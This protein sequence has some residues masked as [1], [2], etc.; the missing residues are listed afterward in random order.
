MDIEKLVRPNIK[1]LKPYSSAR[2]LFTGNQAM[3]L[4]ANENAFDLF[5][6]SLNR[7]PDPLQSELKNK[8]AELKGVTPKNIFLGNGSDEAI[9]L[10][11]RIFCQPG[12]DEVILC[13]P[14]YGMYE[15]MANIH[16]ANIK[17]VLLSP[18]FQLRP[19][20]ILNQ[21]NSSS[22][23]LFLCS[24]NNPTGNLL[25]SE[26]ILELL[27]KFPSIVIVDEAYGDFNAVSWANKVGQFPNLVVL[28][29]LSKAWGLAGLR[30]G[31]AIA[32]EEIVQYLNAVKYPYNISRLNQTAALSALQSPEKMNEAVDLLNSE[33]NELAK[34]LLQLSIVERVFPS[35]ANFILVKFR[36]SSA[37]FEFL[38]KQNIIVRDRS[39]EPLC[40]NCLRLSIGRPEE[41][42]ALFEALK[43]SD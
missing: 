31:M 13:P 6:G 15:V 1:S 25:I 23:L 36:N 3:L 29:T 38:R 43:S 16:G 10:L 4:D 32:S 8:L 12:T 19:D 9:D 5:G 30:L 20:E 18:D 42:Q 17:K 39:K 2:S 26:H 11:L 33:R 35:D 40:D 28:Q 24:P 14:T 37:V 7:Y 21:V 27:G 34:R 22:R 41:N